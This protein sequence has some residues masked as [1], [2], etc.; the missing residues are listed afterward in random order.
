MKGQAAMEMLFI[1]AI[2]ILAASI[3]FVSY[4]EESAHTI[5]ETTIRTQVDLALA[6][7]GMQNASC[8]GTKLQKIEFRL[9]SKNTRE[10]KVITLPASCA[11]SILAPKIGEI[12]GRINEA[13]GCPFTPKHG[14]LL[15]ASCKGKSYKVTY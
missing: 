1:T 5:A 3:V 7:G 9:T 11:K 8:S 15:F 6:K 2:I 4:S 12:H 14:D 10:Y 13:L